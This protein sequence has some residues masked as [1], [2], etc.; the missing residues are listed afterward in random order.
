[1]WLAACDMWW[2]G[3]LYSHLLTCCVTPFFLD[4]AAAGYNLLTV[5]GA[6]ERTPTL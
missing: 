6:E 3:G 4:S 2:L 5:L 1:M